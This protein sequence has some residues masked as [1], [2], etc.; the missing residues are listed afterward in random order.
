MRGIWKSIRLVRVAKAILSCLL[1]GRGTPRPYGLE[2]GEP[3]GFLLFRVELDDERF[4]H[5]RVD[6]GPLRE[7][8][9]LAREALVIG[10]Q[11]GRDGRRQVSGIAHERRSGAAR[12]ERDDVVRADCEARDVDA[13]S[14]D[15]EVA[16][17]DELPRLGPRAGEAEAVDDVVETRLEHAQQV[18]ARSAGAARRLLVRVAELLLEQPV[19]AARLLLLAQ[20][21]QVLALLDPAAAV[22]SRRVRAPLDRALLGQAAFALQEQLDAL[23]TAE[24]TLGAEIA[25]H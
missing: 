11:P 24:P 23:T 10:L 7:A 20:L 5:G 1:S 18:L 12:A 19:V 25:G 4:L 6:L 8:Q 3:P 16:V 14:V 13:P 17:A 15:L 9:H 21:Q 22:L 2:G